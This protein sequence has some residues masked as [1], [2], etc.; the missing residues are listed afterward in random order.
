[1]FGKQRK[2]PLPSF[3]PKAKSHFKRLCEPLPPHTVPQLKEELENFYSSVLAEADNRPLV[4]TE[5][6]RDLYDR[7]CLLLE[8]YPHI[9]E[10]HRSLVVGALRYFVSDDD[11]FSD[12]EFAS[13]FNDDAEVMNHVLEELGL[14]QEVIDIDWGHTTR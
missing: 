4:N 10:K 9:S 3:P 1:M 14:E 12:L 8:R 5:L 6:I 13:G 2:F 11:S 7:A